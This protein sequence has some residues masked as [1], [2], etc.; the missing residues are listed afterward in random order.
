MDGGKSKGFGTRAVYFFTAKVVESTTR[1]WDYLEEIYDQMNLDSVE[2]QGKHK[3]TNRK[4]DVRVTQ[5]F[6]KWLQYNRYQVFK[7][8]Q[9]KCDYVAML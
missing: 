2:S 5:P 8:L 9:N 3:R 7:N 6:A 4:Y 1:L